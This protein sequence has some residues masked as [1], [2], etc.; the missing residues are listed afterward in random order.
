M[1]VLKRNI[2]ANFGGQAA[3]TIIA[4]V[5]VPL[6][7]RFL[8]AEGYGL[9]SFLLA[10]QALTGI[11]DFGLSTTANREVSRYAAQQR[12]AADRQDLVRT[13]EVFYVGTG[14]LIFVALAAMTPW[15]STRWFETSSFSAATLRTCLLIAAASIA[16]R[17]P[18]ALYHG[19][20]RGTE[21]QV[22]LNLVSS[23]TALVRGVGSILVLLFVARDVVVFY[24]WQLAFSGVELAAYLAAASTSVGG[25][26]GRGG[27]FRWELLAGL[28]RFSVRVGALSLFALVL[29]QLDK[30]VISTL[31]PI[32]QLGFY[33]AAN[34][35]ANGIGKAVQP[36]QTAVFP[37]LTQLHERQDE[38][39]APTFH[40]TVQLTAFLSVPLAAALAF[41]PTDVLWVWTRSA[42]LAAQASV[43][44]S[45]LAAAMML[46][47]MMSVPFSLQLAAGLTWIPLATNALGAVTLAPLIYWLVK[48]R[49]LTGGAYAWLIFNA[50]YYVVVPP[51]MFRY[52]L[53]NRE[54]YR[55]WLT[56]DTLPFMVCGVAFFGAA[57]LLAGDATLAVKVALAAAALAA[58][59]A[60]ML[61]VIPGLRDSLASSPAALRLRAREG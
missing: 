29:K 26:T 39:I 37:R 45:V 54:H 24:W 22:R 51:V 49:G 38:T 48:T 28:W 34:L 61:A 18:A 1:S 42:E 25:F 57:R 60:T 15:L 40:R 6:Y 30:L 14:A 17:W 33:N 32:A 27:A 52:V 3:L 41:F 12:P 44:L 13:L 11:I 7:L 53:T 4:F 35:A 5:T 2:L 8:G 19:I 16:L 58:Y 36:V 31:L 56:Q 20:L 9:V 21:Q 47:S 43:A 50:V 55:R 46:N 23:T 10:L 59:G